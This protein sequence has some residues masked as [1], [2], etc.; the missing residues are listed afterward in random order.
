MP[1]TDPNY[2]S[3]YTNALGK[4]LLHSHD[5]AVLRVGQDVA[6]GVERYRYVRM[7]QHLGDDLGVDVLEQQYGRG[8]VP[9]LVERHRWEPGALYERSKGPPA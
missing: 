6:V 4:G 7:P 5:D 1:S 9:E 2:T 3:F 8:G